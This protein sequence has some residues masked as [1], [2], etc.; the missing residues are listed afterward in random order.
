MI[1]QPITIN[2][3]QFRN[4]ILRSAMGGR[5]ANYDG[6]VTSVW[7]NFEKQ[8]AD[9]GVGGI[10]STTLNVNASRH[11][12]FE[13]PP[14][15]NDDFVPPLKRYIREIQEG[16]CRYIIQIGDP[17]YVT[18]TSLF[19]ETEDTHSSS[20]G[21]DLLY[22]YGNRRTEMSPPVIERAIDNFVA[23]AARVQDTG[24]DGL[25][26]TA[27]KGYL[28]HQFLNPG[29]NRRKDQWGSG[30]PE[31]KRFLF[32]QRIIE[33][34]R[35]KLGAGFLLGVK[36][37][38]RDDNYL[39]LQ[40]IRW[41][42]MWNLKHQFLGNTET[43]TL[44][45]AQELERLGVDYL[46]LV[47]GCGF[48]SPKDTPGRFPAEEAR[49][50]FNSTRH[51]SGKAAFRASV[52][53]VLS[54]L[55][56]LVN[57]GW[58]RELPPGGSS[59]GWPSA[60]ANVETA[61]KFKQQ[62]KKIHIIVNGGMKRRDLIESALETGKCDMVSIGRGLLAHP[63]LVQQFQR[64]VNEPDNSCT[65]CNRCAGRTPTSPLGCYNPDRFNGDLALMHRQILAHN[66]PD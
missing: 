28:I 17:G 15:S 35:G 19:A 65:Y 20:S 47:S 36:L 33:R 54:R 57:P 64:G 29:L 1:F 60:G 27:S 42:P 23:A 5:M 41:P 45:F 66:R 59:V 26:V 40:N 46:H 8:F 22:G 18:Q 2:G 3:V 16:G 9:G 39:P 24:A 51:L 50:F 25:E 61:G 44:R 63:D 43:E 6:T 34:I 4:R 55:G 37:S 48:I 14:I 31:P 62:L 49:L 10:V 38:T 21:F 53:N 58:E 30:G 11:S 7:K 52:G 13:Y 12:P 32:L 56:W